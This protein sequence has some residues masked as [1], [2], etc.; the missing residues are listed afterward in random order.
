MEL[1]PIIR[2]KYCPHFG[3]SLRRL[4]EITRRDLAFLKQETAKAEADVVNYQAEKAVINVE[5][6]LKQHEAIKYRLAR[7][8]VEKLSGDVKDF[9]TRHAKLLVEF[10]ENASPGS[11]IDLPKNLQG[12]KEYNTFILSKAS[13]DEIPNYN[14]LLNVPGEILINE[15]GINIKAYIKARDEIK[16]TPDTDIAY[17]DYDKIE[18]NLIIRNRLPGDR[19]KPLGGM[20]F[21][22]LKDFFIDEKVPRRKR[23]QIPIVEANGRIVWVGGMRIDDRYK[24]TGETKEC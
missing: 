23:N 19:F 12:I 7:S 13:F 10:I 18:S 9:E 24:V 16:I 4:S 11:M 22:K 2:K 20:G 21:K 1:I 14:Y 17:L 5:K 15:L 6:F 3:Q 8:V